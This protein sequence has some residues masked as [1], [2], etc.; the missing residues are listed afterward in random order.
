MTECKR[1]RVG[2]KGR[3]GCAE[4]VVF[5]FG[6]G[7]RPT[8]R[9][10][11]GAVTSDAGLA[12]LRQA[13]ERLGLFAAAAGMIEDRRW[14]PMVVHP[15]GRLLREVVYAYAAGY[16]DGNDHPRLAADELFAALIGPVTTGGINPKRH[17]GLASE[18][19]ISRLLGE[20]RMAFAALEAIHR[21]WFLLSMCRRQPPVLTLDIDG[22][23]AET[24]GQQQLSLYN[25]YYGQYMYY[26]LQIS[27][28]EY[29]FVV[30][31]LLRPGDAPGNGGAA[32]Q[33]RPL[34]EF[35]R[36]SFPKTRLRLRADSGF[37]DPEIYDLCEEFSVEYAVRLK[38]NK[39]LKALIAQLL[40]PRVRREI[41]LE[42]RT[43][44]WTLYAECRYRA[45]TW[46]R[47]RRVVLKLTF[48]PAKDEIERYAIVTNSAR[49]Q[50][51][52]WNFYAHRG[53]CEQ[54]IDELKN[55]LRAEKLSCTLF[56][57]NAVKLHL[58]VMAHNL[59]AAVRILLPD[60]HEL[61]RATVGQLRIR[62]VKC[63]AT[64]RRTARRLWI[65]ASRSWPFRELLG[66]VAE[67]MVRGPLCPVPL[68]NSG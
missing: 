41:P 60:R 26:P 61:K 42:R 27:V 17:A 9:F 50:R 24:H 21:H 11:A 47:A 7:V 57:P 68:W 22:F 33:L 43:S 35:L 34:L 1:E 58:V 6:G 25:D 38:M 51:K 48:N 36:G 20:R 13:D 56:A 53:Q 63:G 31:A 62:L 14:A 18:A 2:S 32:A 30:G 59:F 19:T 3:G 44:R 10:D 52:V 37:M 39:L 16:E 28:A 67:R 55:H 29:G 15:V 12:A 45:G 46:K 8:L 65:H 4:Q 49:A 23:D 66:N 40:E 54:R 64:I 5:D